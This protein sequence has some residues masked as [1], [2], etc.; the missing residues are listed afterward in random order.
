MS[1]NCSIVDYGRSRSLTLVAVA[2]FIALSI[3][4]VVAQPAL[5][6]TRIELDPYT[7][8]FGWVTEPVIVGERNEILIE[9]FEGDAPV[10]GVESTLEIEVLYG[11][12]TYLGTLTPTEKPG[13]Y[14]VDIFPTVR[15]QY[16]IHLVGTIGDLEVDEFVEPEEV[17][18]AKVVQFPEPQPDPIELQKNIDELQAQL[19]TTNFLAIIGV[20]TGVAGIGLS[21]FSILRRS[22][23]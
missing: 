22:K 18:P 2:I 20:A 1:R 16:E 3:A 11:G 23:Q 14:V 17:L 6:H 10:T 9:V 13:W 15:G 7:I 12:R 8:I 21:A 4:G 19:E 5:A